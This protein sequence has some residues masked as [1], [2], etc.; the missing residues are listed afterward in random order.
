MMQLEWPETS[1]VGNEIDYDYVTVGKTYYVKRPAYKHEQEA[2]AKKQ[3][4]TLMLHQI[5]EEASYKILVT[6]KE[7]KLLN[8]GQLTQTLNGPGVKFFES[9]K[10]SR[11][12]KLSR[13]EE[14][15]HENRKISLANPPKVFTKVGGKTRRRRRKLRKTRHRR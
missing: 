14:S 7:G 10:S 9:L 11:K 3:P 15:L 12:E 6:L 5:P 8:R 2:W 1:D 13:S 4:E